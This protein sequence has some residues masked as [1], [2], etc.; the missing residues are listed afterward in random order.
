MKTIRIAATAL[1]VCLFSNVYAQYAL[2][3]GKFQFNGGLGINQSIWGIP[4]YAGFD[5]GFDK[6]ISF[7]GDLSVRTFVTSA[8]YSS[9]FGLS[10]NANYHFVDL[11]GINDIYDVY[12]GVDFGFYT[13]LNKPNAGAHIGARYYFNKNVALNAELGGSVAFSAGKV[14]LSVLLDQD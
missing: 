9:I 10:A 5:Y 3:T 13:G 4:L 14:G 11:L 6:N 7:G 12:A 8:D 1:M 2:Q